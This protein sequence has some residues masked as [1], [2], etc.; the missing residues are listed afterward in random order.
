MRRKE[1]TSSGDAS[2]A[3]GGDSLAPIITNPQIYVSLEGEVPP[4]VT[5]WPRVHE[6]DALTMGVHKA[7]TLDGRASLPP[8]ILR[9]A[10]KEV[11]AQM[12]RAAIHGG[13]V[14]L[15][16]DSTSGKTRTAFHGIQRCMPDHAVYAPVRN[17]RLT[18]VVHL[19]RSAP[20]GKFL[21]WLDDLEGFLG[22]DGM[23]TSLLGTLE[24]M[25]VTVVATMQDDL[26]ATYSNPK[27]ESG[28]DSSLHIGNRL[29]RAVEPI[30]ITRLWSSKEIRRAS[31]VPDDRLTEAITHSATFG[32]SEYLAAGPA[33]MKTWRNA[34]RV[35]GNPRGAALVQTSVDLARAGFNAAVDID[36]LEELH[37]Q[38]LPDATLRPESWDEAKKWATAVQYG[39]SG[40]LVPGEDDA[41][42]RAFDYLPDAVSRD[43]ENQS[44]IPESI[45]KEAL[46]LSPDDDD[47]WLIGMRAYMA[48]KNEH[49]I[50]AWEPLAEN[51]NGSAAS[52]LAEIYLETGDVEAAQYWRSIESEDRFHTDALPL[53]PE[54]RLYDPDTGMVSAGKYRDG[55]V[56][57]IPLHRPGYG[58]IHGVIAGGR[59]VERATPSP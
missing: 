8:Y 5:D 36:V 59:G 6:V 21:V 2:V 54:I 10:D 12:K 33:L 27:Q 3:I 39:V 51:G 58:V 35:G 44:E 16:G 56:I 32:V 55:T 17:S 57:Q 30:R 34:E 11:A 42:W 20:G 40:L 31:R 52:N 7:R 45:W 48:G 49:A 50:A 15:T 29:L 1:V 46:S 38:Y 22:Q 4:E 23:N 53:D 41:T 13:M 26:F 19:L 24:R 43:K 47:R 18:P 25:R 37:S 9:D 28:R 14:L